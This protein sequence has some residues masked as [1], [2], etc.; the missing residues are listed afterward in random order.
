ME[1]KLDDEIINVLVS[2]ALKSLEVV[3]L[4]EFGNQALSKL[5]R[6]NLKL[7]IQVDQDHL[8]LCLAKLRLHEF[9]LK[10]LSLSVE[11]KKT[12]NARTRD[13][14]D[15]ISKICQSHYIGSNL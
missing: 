2:Y 1:R 6:D 4:K 14:S 3:K 13:I 11:K 8:R 15:Y 12:D 7:K 9:Y 10:T 5:E